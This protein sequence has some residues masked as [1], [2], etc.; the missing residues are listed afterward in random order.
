[1]KV[2]ES[3]YLNGAANAENDSINKQMKEHK[4]ARLDINL[5]YPNGH[6]VVIPQ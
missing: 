5:R 1:M 6:T 3:D 4:Y 2:I